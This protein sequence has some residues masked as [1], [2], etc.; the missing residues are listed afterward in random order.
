MI[1]TLFTAVLLSLSISSQATVITF[2]DWQYNSNDHID[3]LVTVD[4]ESHEDYFTFNISIGEENPS[5]DVLGF[6]FD[7]QADFN[8]AGDLVNY[9]A[10][11]LSAYGTNSLKCGRG[12]NFN[13]AVRN[14][15]DYIF[16]VG[17]QG[18][19]ND[20]VSE[21]SFGLAKNGL[22]LDQSLFTRVGIR[23][24]SVG[25]NCSSSNCG[26][27]VKDYSE[28]PDTV[29]PVPPSD[30]VIQVPEPATALLFGLALFGFAARRQ[31]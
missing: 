6:A 14:S 12:C 9:S 22:T 30:D 2:N 17:Q 15:F 11:E 16:R 27:S 25:S 18:S 31:R 10:Y 13:G 8:L 24:Q 26:G 19:G 20:Y 3:W 1:K 23:A 7:S 4:D 28:T 21:F 29:I 5:G